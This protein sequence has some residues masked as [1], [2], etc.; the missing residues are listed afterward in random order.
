MGC[1]TESETPDIKIIHLSCSPLAGVLWHGGSK[2]GNDAPAGVSPMW[3]TE[4]TSQPTEAYTPPH[5]TGDLVVDP[6]GVRSGG[7][8][9]GSHYVVGSL[10]S[11]LPWFS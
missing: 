11:G 3:G 6:P 1:S 7:V 10:L 5:L 2:G 8:K 4:G 9:M